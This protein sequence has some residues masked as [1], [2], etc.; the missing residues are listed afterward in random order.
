MSAEP[1]AAAAATPSATGPTCHRCHEQIHSQF[2]K[3]G[4]YAFHRDH[5]NCCVCE[6]LLVDSNDFRL[7][8]G[9][10]YCLQHYEERCVFVVVVFKHLC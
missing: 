10:F 5:F 3:V 8:D 4:D 9:D 7:K 6:K 2:Y 1:E